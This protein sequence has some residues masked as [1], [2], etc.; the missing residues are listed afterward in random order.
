VIAE[1]VETMDQFRFLRD[2]GCLSYQ[3]YLFG[4][5]APAAVWLARWRTDSCSTA[6]S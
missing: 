4:K 3:G 6:S 2:H 5:P 1:G